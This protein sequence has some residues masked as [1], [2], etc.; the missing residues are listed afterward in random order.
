[1]DISRLEKDVVDQIVELQVKLGYAYEST[2]F[3]YKVES[4]N[5]LIGTDAPTAAA[6]C[7][8]LSKQKALQ[9]SPLGAV[10]YGVHADRIEVR[11]PPQGSKYVHEEVPAPQFLID[12]IE[13]FVTKHH[14]S[15]D[16]V[17]ALFGKHSA[18]YVL[19]EMPEGAE[20]DY[21]MHFED[22]SIDTH[23]YCFKEEM[24]HLIYH[25]F[26]KEDY[27]RLLD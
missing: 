13:L 12:L 15:K 25:R 8:L 10:S 19:E 16:E 14:P 9:D 21:G 17:I 5:S 3:Y 27:E 24:G 6:L 22:Q 11:I 20:F 23:Y 26:A 7:E 2:R 1:M 18:S 4:L